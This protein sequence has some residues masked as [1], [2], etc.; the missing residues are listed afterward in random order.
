M[1]CPAADRQPAAHRASNSRLHT[2]EL[3]LMSN[4][5][6]CLVVMLLPMGAGIAHGQPL[7][8]KPE[9]NVE[10]IVG[11]SPGGTVDQ[12]ARTIQKIWQDKRLIGTVSSVVNKAGGGGAVGWAYLNQHR[13]DG[14]Y[15]EIGSATQLTNHI[16]GKSSLNYTEF[17][18][19]ALLF[20]E[21]VAFAVRP[22]SPIKTGRALIDRIK[23]EPASLSFA[24]ATSAGNTSHIAVGL[25]GK[26]AGIEPRQMKVVVFNSGGDLVTALLGGHVDVI[27]VS[28]LAV[29]PHLRAGTMQVIAL[30]A[31]QRFGGVFANVPTWNEQAV[32]VVVDN[33][34]S[35]VGPPDIGPAQVAYWQG[36]VAAL[37]QFEEWKTDLEQNF[38]VP[39][40]LNS[41]ETRKYLDSEY[42]KLRAILSELGLAK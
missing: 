3:N 23:K 8:W 6:L 27:V 31:P 36:L 28:A 1:I 16:T 2:R 22:G 38:W 39:K 11:T 37:A 42:N 13:G 12:S 40:Q 5:H 35:L 18:P 14:H 10:I 24:V 30:A 21:Y 34:R 20:S 33:F 17:T 4:I 32:D 26:G 9:K 41:A 19:I 15:L 7:P 25:V 29:V